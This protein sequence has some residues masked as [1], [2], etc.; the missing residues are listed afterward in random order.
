V[1]HGK[2]VLDWICSATGLLVLLPLFAPVAM[3][4]KLT[5]RGQVFYRQM[6]VGKD[7]QPFQIVKFHSMN[8][9]ASEM[10]PGI[11]V[12]GDERIT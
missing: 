3:C 8:G 7:G 1:R 12:S 11:T 5:S 2:R 6:R 9:A 10:S 4:I